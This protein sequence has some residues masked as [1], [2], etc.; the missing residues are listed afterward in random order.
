MKYSK[1]SLKPQN[2]IELVNNIK[3]NHKKMFDGSN[4][5]YYLFY[6]ID[7]FLGAKIQSGISEEIDECFQFTF[8]KWLSNRCRKDIFH[9][10][11]WVKIVKQLSEN[12]KEFEFFF[13]YF[14]DFIDEM[15][16]IPR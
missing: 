4:D 5:I 9:D 13:Q 10:T 7:G 16:K 14:D 15:D 2:I 8:S 3:L 12:N 6:F 11:S 1:E